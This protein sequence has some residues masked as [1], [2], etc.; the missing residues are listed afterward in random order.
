MNIEEIIKEYKIYIGVFLV[1]IGTFIVGG[2][3][4]TGFVL[5]LMGI[6]ILMTW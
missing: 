3:Q 5:A 2:I 4:V 1:V 6:G